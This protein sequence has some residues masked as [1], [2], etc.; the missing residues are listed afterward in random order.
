M[1]ATYLLEKQGT[2][3]SSDGKTWPSQMT[4]IRFENTNGSVLTEGNAGVGDIGGVLLASGSIRLYTNV[5]T[6][7]N[8]I[9]YFSKA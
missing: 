8:D 1:Y 9:A 4:D 6:P 3:F 7:S 2:A 5:G